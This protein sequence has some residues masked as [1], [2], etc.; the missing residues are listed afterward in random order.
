MRRAHYFCVRHTFP[1]WCAQCSVFKA[2]KYVIL[3]VLTR[4]L[5]ILRKVTF[6]IVNV[7]YSCASVKDI[8]QYLKKGRGNTRDR[9][10]QTILLTI[11]RFYYKF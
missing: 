2:S 4:I 8:K 5:F 1:G 10:D 11:E 9:K 7:W 3:S 6:F